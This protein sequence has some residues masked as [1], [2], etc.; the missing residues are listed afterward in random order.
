M[1]KKTKILGAVLFIGLLAYEMLY[2]GIKVFQSYRQLT[3]HN[4]QIIWDF[5]KKNIPKGSKV[6]AE[7][8]FYYAIT[9][10]GS[11]MMY[12]NL[13]GELPAREQYHRQTWDYDYLLL[14][15]ANRESNIAQ[16]YKSHSKLVCLDSL[17]LESSNFWLGSTHEKEGYSA[18][19]F[20]RIR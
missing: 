7:P 3:T 8:I 4:H 18:I 13:F 2:F 6:V 17:L 9:E 10:S 15:Y 5:V 20:K 16:F 1:L 12:A 11:A 14:R 19:L